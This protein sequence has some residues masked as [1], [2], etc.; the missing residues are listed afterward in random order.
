[1]AGCIKSDPRFPGVDQLILEYAKHAK[2]KCETLRTD[3]DVFDVWSDFVVAGEQVTGFEPVRS[4]NPD[5]Q[6]HCS[7]LFLCLYVLHLPDQLR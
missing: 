7:N 4:D 5:N 6:K 3:D 2:H 1:M